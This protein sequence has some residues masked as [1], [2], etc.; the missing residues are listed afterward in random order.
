MVYT[1]D[2]CAMIA[3]FRSEVG[4]EKLLD[5]FQNQEHIFYMH[6]IN[7]GE[8]YYDFYRVAG[9]DVADALFQDI[10]DLPI[11]VIWEIDKELIQRV[12]FYKVNHKV[13][14]ADCYFLALTEKLKAI[15]IS[16]DHHEFDVIEESKLVK[17]YWLR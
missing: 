8:V 16:T 5:L 12:G 17:F 6:S 7:L 10:N 14:Y 3:Y 13:S 4:G 9:K 15:A 1:L 2:A 11:E